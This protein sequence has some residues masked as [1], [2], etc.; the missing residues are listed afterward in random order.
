MSKRLRYQVFAACVAAVAVA[1]VVPAAS[2]V[3]FGSA[4]ISVDSP[5]M[6]ARVAVTVPVQYTCAPLDSFSFG[7]VIVV[8]TQASGEKIA[9]G[10]AQTGNLEPSTCDNAPHTVSLTVFASS[11]PFHGGQAVVQAS[12]SACGT[13]DSVFGCESASTGAQVVNIRA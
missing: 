7:N 4:S 8:V 5:T 2:A 9:T 6:L 12:L 13:I 3:V 10:S 11:T 1:I